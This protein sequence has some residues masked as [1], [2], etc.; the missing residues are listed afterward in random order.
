MYP[1]GTL[2]EN[3]CDFAC[4]KYSWK[5]R[6][7]YILHIFYIHIFL[8][9]SKRCFAIGFLVVLAFLKGRS[10][11]SRNSSIF[12]LIPIRYFSNLIFRFINLYK[13]NLVMVLIVLSFIE[14]VL[15][16]WSML[17]LNNYK[18]VSNFFGLSGRFRFLC[19]INIKK[20]EYFDFL[21]K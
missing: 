8:I 5:D 6:Y 16:F 4:F 1:N 21:Q 12:H 18:V 17:L 14:K 11:K 15:D 10:L 9:T 20:S 7:T 13:N 2:F 3:C 19:Y